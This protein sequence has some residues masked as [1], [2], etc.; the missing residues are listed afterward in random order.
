[1][2]RFCSL[3][4][5][6]GNDFTYTQK[7]KLEQ[8]ALTP[9]KFPGTEMPYFSLD[10]ESYRKVSHEAKTGAHSTRFSILA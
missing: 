1:M 6:N 8:V 7:V 4:P 10:L 2:K 3:F 5:Y 9:L